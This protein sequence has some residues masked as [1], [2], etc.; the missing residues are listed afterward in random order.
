MEH[1]VTGEMDIFDN[2]CTPNY[3]IDIYQRWGVNCLFGY[4]YQG[5]A[6]DTGGMQC[7]QIS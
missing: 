3:Q 6:V 4:F 5:S 2:S 7:A 1:L